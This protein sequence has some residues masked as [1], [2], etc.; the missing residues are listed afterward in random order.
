MTRFACLAA[1]VAM[2]LLTGCDGSLTTSTTDTNTNG[3]TD[4]TA[5]TI[6]NCTPSSGAAELNPAITICGTNLSTITEVAIGDEQATI[7]WRNSTDALIEIP[8]TATTGFITVTSPG[9]SATSSTQFT[10]TDLD[11]TEATTLVVGALAEVAAM[12]ADATNTTSNGTLLPADANAETNGLDTGSEA[13]T[14]GLDE[15]LTENPI[16]AALLLAGRDSTGATRHGAIEDEE[17]QMNEVLSSLVKLWLDRYRSGKVWTSGEINVYY[18]PDCARGVVLDSSDF[19]WLSHDFPF[20][21]RG[22]VKGGGITVDISGTLHAGN[23]RLQT[24]FDG[25]VTKTA[26]A[27][28]IDGTGAVTVAGEDYYFTCNDLTIESG[29]KMPSSGSLVIG[30]PPIAKIE[31]QEDTP[32]TGE[33]SITT[34]GETF[35]QQLPD[36]STGYYSDPDVYNFTGLWTTSSASANPAR[37][38]ELWKIEETGSFAVK[39]GGDSLTA[40]LQ[41]GEG[42]PDDLADKIDDLKETAEGYMTNGYSRNDQDQTLVEKIEEFFEKFNKVNDTFDAETI[43][44]LYLYSDRNYK[45]RYTLGLFIGK[46]VGPRAYAFYTETTYLKPNEVDSEIEYGQTGILEFFMEHDK[47]FH[48]QAYPLFP[49]SNFQ[50]LVLPWQEYCHRTGLFVSFELDLEDNVLSFEGS[51]SQ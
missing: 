13:N 27:V 5:P 34:E 29:E 32:D 1:L 10:V 43:S 24:W 9:G 25:T 3:N 23:N 50:G 12:A 36:P 18:N 45:D 47:A 26:T 49:Y 40:M 42:L 28:I 48:V 41:E 6:T 15:D 35:D 14:T 11:Y 44:G 39:T 37:Y 2:L 16:G 22:C 46:A 31:F 38:Q 33:V 51:Y 8:N 21:L 19:Q 17:S 4:A 20:E 30:I 7:L